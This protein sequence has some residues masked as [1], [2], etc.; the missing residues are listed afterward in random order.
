MADTPFWLTAAAGL[1]LGTL[2]GAV[3]TGVMNWQTAA[4]QRDLEKE[5]RTADHQQERD[6]REMDHRNQLELERLKDEHQ[7]RDQHLASLRRGLASLVLAALNTERF[8]QILPND[9][10]VSHP[11]TSRG[12]RDAGGR[13]ME[14]PA[15]ENSRPQEGCP[16]NHR[17]CR[18][19]SE[20]NKA[21][22]LTYDGAVAVLA[23]IL[24]LGQPTTRVRRVVWTL[25][26]SADFRRQY[27]STGEAALRHR[28]SSATVVRWIRDGRLAAVR[29]GPRLFVDRREFAA[30]VKQL[31][32]PGTRTRAKVR[33]HQR[34]MTLRR[35]RRRVTYES[36]RRII[37]SKVAVTS[38]APPP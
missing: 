18:P 1:G 17:P 3:I 36:T 34:M 8:I 33:K 19:R 7:R 2:V 30:F 4:K 24:P 38:K 26:Q 21:L 27:W 31:P 32:K 9:D 35:L 13:G 23:P 37:R 14:R 16:G 20:L 10:P 22:V 12:L 29:A 25:S 11:R 5:L 6:M 15:S 28:M